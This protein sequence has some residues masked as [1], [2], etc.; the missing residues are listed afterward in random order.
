MVNSWQCLGTLAV[1]D[2]RVIRIV[3]IKKTNSQNN[4]TVRC[5]IG[6]GK[7][8]KQ[9][10]KNRVS[11]DDRNVTRMKCRLF[12]SSCIGFLSRWSRK[13]TRRENKRRG[14]KCP[15]ISMNAFPNGA[16]RR[17]SARVSTTCFIWLIGSMNECYIEI[18]Q[19]FTKVK[20]IQTLSW[21]LDL[22]MTAIFCIM[23]LMNECEYIYIYILP[24]FRVY[25]WQR[26]NARVHPSVRRIL[27]SN[28]R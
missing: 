13:Q 4:F 26:T 16:E 28:H 10:L 27:N 3:G 17:R 6:V 14:N 21:Y 23:P 25:T 11:R 7:K 20:T 24:P 19:D 2:L 9:I 8:K 15:T 22:C 1:S 5:E 12:V 18:N